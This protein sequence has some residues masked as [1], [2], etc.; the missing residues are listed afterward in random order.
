MDI[1][2]KIEFYIKHIFNQMDLENQGKINFEKYSLALEKDPN[3]LEIY[4]FMNNSFNNNI[5]ANSNNTSQAELRD[6]MIDIKNLEINLDKLCKYLDNH[7]K[8]QNS[9]D[10]VLQNSPDERNNNKGAQKSDK[11]N[12]LS[13][14]YIKINRREK[15]LN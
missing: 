12:F 7:Y 2:R 9:K 10:F 15:T 4:E 3:I 8:T 11:N 5:L 6:L 14:K 13:A 1:T